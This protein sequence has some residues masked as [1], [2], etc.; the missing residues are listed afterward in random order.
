MANDWKEILE[1]EYGALE[2]NEVPD[3]QGP[4]GMAVV[5]LGGTDYRLIVADPYIPEL[6]LLLQDEWTPEEAYRLTRL[7]AHLKTRRVVL[8]SGERAREDFLRSLRVRET[9]CAELLRRNL[10]K[11]GAEEYL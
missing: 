4:E 2:Q 8:A 7:F 9:I 3:A 1:D 6:P 5:A 10:Q 11:G